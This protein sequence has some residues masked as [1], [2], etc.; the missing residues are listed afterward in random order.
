MSITICSSS[1][2][3]IILNEFMKLRG[4]RSSF[5]RA[6]YSNRHTMPQNATDKAANHLETFF[7]IIL[8]IGI[9]CISVIL[10]VI[11]LNT[12]TSYRN[13]C[14]FDYLESLLDEANHAKHI[15]KQ[16]CFTVI[17]VYIFNFSHNN[18]KSGMKCGSELIFYLFGEEHTEMSHDVAA[19]NDTQNQIP[20]TDISFNTATNYDDSMTSDIYNSSTTRVKL[21]SKQSCCSC[22]IFNYYFL[23][24]DKKSLQVKKIES[25]IL[26]IYFLISVGKL[27]FM[28]KSQLIYMWSLAYLT[29]NLI[30]I[31]AVLLINYFPYQV[32]VDLNASGQ[33]HVHAKTF[34]FRSREETALITQQQAAST[35]SSQINSDAY[36]ATK[37]S[38]FTGGDGDI[39]DGDAELENDANIIEN[40]FAEHKQTLRDKAFSNKSLSFGKNQPSMISAYKVSRII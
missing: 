32:L 33:Q 5:E 10:F 22:W 1:L 17:C 30:I 24:F 38:E 2:F 19:S 31:S 12:L 35:S 6:H 9:T 16:L 20:M 3:T 37:T 21:T 23:F 40:A 13:L 11:L 26:T 18:L 25:L 4:N 29:M 14:C 7:K 34:M 36:A 28:E 8:K 27:F 39:A 15:V